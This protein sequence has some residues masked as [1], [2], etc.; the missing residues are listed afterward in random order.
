[1]EKDAEAALQYLSENDY[2]HRY[3]RHGTQIT[4]LLVA[5]PNAV[6]LARIY[7]HVLMLDCTYNT[8]RWKL[9]M[10]HVVGK[11]AFGN[12]FTVCIA[13]LQNEQISSYKW[14]PEQ[15]RDLFGD[16]KLPKVVL[17]DED[18]ALGIALELVLPSS[19]HFLCRFHIMMNVTAM[20]T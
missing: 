3:E 11:D 20:S 9:P 1:V 19:Q 16:E 12:S 17:T 5:H 4:K 8:N 13:F 6:S 14:A 10:L 7:H 18:Q 15:L 2:F